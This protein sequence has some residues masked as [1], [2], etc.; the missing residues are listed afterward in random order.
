MLKYITHY[1]IRGESIS[2]ATCRTCGNQ[3]NTD[4]LRL[5]ADGIKTI[6]GATGRNP[7]AALDLLSNCCDCCDNPR[8]TYYPNND[9]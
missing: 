5:G 9:W 8:Y 6:N 3:V 2:V 1:N 7:L 4:Q